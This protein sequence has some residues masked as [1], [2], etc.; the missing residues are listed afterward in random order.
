MPTLINLSGLRPDQAG[1]PSFKTH[2]HPAIYD[3]QL[4]ASLIKKK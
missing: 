3:R 4:C 1:G 2:H